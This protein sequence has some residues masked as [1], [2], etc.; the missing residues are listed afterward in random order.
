M[1]TV[2]INGIS[3]PAEGGSRIADLPPYRAI[4]AMPCG[5]RSVCGKCKVQAE[6]ALSAP[7]AAER[8]T[9]TSDELAAGIRLACH[10]RILGDCRITLP[11]AAGDQVHLAGEGRATA[12]HPAFARY[13]I[14]LDIGTTTLAAALYDRAGHLLAKAGALNPQKGFGADVISRMEAALAGNAHTLAVLL[15]EGIDELIRTLCRDGGISPY[16]VD[17]M[18]VTGNTVML[19]LL[20]ETD[21]EPLTHAPFA[22]RRLFGECLTAE[23]LGLTALSP[24][25]EIYLPPCAAAFVGADLICALMATRPWEGEGA[26]LLIDIGTNGEMALS[27][28]GKLLFC[29]TAA[30]PAFE[31]AGLSMGMSGRVGAIDRV[32]L[33]SGR[34]APHVIGDILPVGICGSGVVDA[35]ACLLEIGELDE[36]GYLEN[37]PAL[38][39][40]PVSIT[41]QDVRAIQLAKSAIYA[42]IRTLLTKADL[43]TRQVNRLYIAGGFGSYLN[44]VSAGKIGL[45]PAELIPTVRVVGNAALEGAAIL[46]L[47][48][49]QRTRAAELSEAPVADLATDPAFASYYMEGMLFTSSD[50]DFE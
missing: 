14:A 38:I 23:E 2:W 28:E 4:A 31:G 3:Y 43:Q 46:L 13:G 11:D 16:E 24:A 22:A 5:G 44:V 6:G 19:H 26:S 1:I 36:S 10:A 9:L 39:Y 8:E 34:L 25:C 17:A 12:V 49:A 41:A 7:D 21:V 33:R 29:S 27:H 20:T 50:S 48:S 47:D 32:E 18:T 40:P 35:I 15:R 45:I 37:S 30:G 42:G